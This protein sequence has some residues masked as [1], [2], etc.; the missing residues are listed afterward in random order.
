MCVR[1][2]R[3]EAGTATADIVNWIEFTKKKKEE[4]LFKRA[5]K[6]QQQTEEV[7]VWPEGGK[8]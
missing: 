5:K 3:N 1:T 4:D 7:S 8:E 6:N 2:Q